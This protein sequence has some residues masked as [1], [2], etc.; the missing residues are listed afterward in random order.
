[1][2]TAEELE[3]KRKADEEKAQREGAESEEESS[4]DEEELT[5]ELLQAKLAEQQKH[6]KNLN[7]ESADRRKK[8]D[9]FEKQ[10]QDRKQ[11][12][13]TEVEK[14]KQRADQLEQEKKTLAMENQTLKRQRDFEGLVRDAGL[15]FK[16]T[17]AAKDA[18]KALVEILGD[19]ETEVT[20]EHIKQL[21]KERDYYFGKP[22]PSQI[23][24]DGSKK[25][26]SNST[27]TT[28]DAI[29]AKRK[30]ISPI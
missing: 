5:V 24:T 28:Q 27:V 13:L 6:I 19:D 11:A 16:N 1:M 8:L 22:D 9:E 2:P 17:L 10:E 20:E 21:V 25:G 30:L 3:A 18:F 29:A 26:K 14:V 4:E 15:Q 23:N 12:E 7:K